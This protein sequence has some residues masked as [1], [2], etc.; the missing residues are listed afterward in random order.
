MRLFLTIFRLEKRGARVV[1]DFSRP[2]AIGPLVRVLR[3]NRREACL[4]DHGT[5]GRGPGLA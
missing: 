1:V 2:D 4:G 3:G 5:C